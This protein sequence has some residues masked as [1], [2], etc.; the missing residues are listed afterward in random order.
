VL[1]AISRPDAG[2]LGVYAVLSFQSR[3]TQ[4]FG[5]RVALGALPA[6]CAGWSFAKALSRAQLAP[7]GVGGALVAMCI[8]TELHG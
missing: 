7:A 3:R 2:Q 8:A 1:V 4:E 6:T 5:I